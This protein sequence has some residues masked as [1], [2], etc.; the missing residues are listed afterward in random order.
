[1]PTWRVELHEGTALLV[2]VG[3]LVQTEAG[4]EWWTLVQVIHEPSWVCVRRVFKADAVSVSE[5]S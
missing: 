3:Q 1:M 5:L 4:W 2:D